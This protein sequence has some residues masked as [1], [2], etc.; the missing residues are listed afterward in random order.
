MPQVP[1]G[2][3]LN[4]LLQ[5]F[6]MAVHP[7]VLFAGYAASVVPFA[8][9]VAA[10]LKNEY[11]IMTTKA[12]RWVILSAALLG[13]GIF[14][15]GY[16]AYAVLG[17]GGYWGWDPVENSSLIPWLLLIALIHGLIVQRRKGAL[18]RTNCAIAMLQYLLVLYSTFLTRSGILSE[19]SVHSFSQDSVS[20]QILFYILFFMVVS[21]ALFALRFKTSRGVPLEQKTLTPENILVFGILVLLLYASMIFI[22]TSMPIFTRLFM[23]HPSTVTEEFYAIWSLPAG[24]MTLSFIALVAFSRGAQFETK[25]F[26]I[27]FVGSI[28]GGVLFNMFKTATPGAYLLTIAALFAM[29][30]VCRDWFLRQS[31]AHRPSRIVHTATAFLMLGIIASTYHSLSTQPR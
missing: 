10:L 16:W 4:P 17:W 23:S 13:G 28:I 24:I 29:V 18:V 19:F 1:D 12:Y 7:P 31:K 6:W 11:D 21:I 20:Y 9:A 5:D 27:L 22:G 25:P 3:G 15:G 14:L 8:Y 30:S 26:I 2:L